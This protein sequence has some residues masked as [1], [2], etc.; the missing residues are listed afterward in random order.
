MASQAA[1][2]CASGT[3]TR[4]ARA[5]GVRRKVTVGVRTGRITRQCVT[6][7]AAGLGVRDLEMR[8]VVELA[9]PYGR[10][11]APCREPVHIDR[12]AGAEVHGMATCAGT[13]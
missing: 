4:G 9:P 11:L 8:A 13:I 7:C 12:P 6:V 2:F 3:V 1:A 5:D 10:G